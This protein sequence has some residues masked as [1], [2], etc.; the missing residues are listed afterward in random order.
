MAGSDVIHVRLPESAAP[1][2]EEIELLQ[3][4]FDAIVALRFGQSP[5]SERVLGALRADGWQVRS[6][7]GWVAE[8]KRGGESEQVTG[9]TQTEAL[10]HLEQLIKA[11]RV[12]SAP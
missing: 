7:L 11:D 9:A 10:V 4:L 8:A 5:T 1:S 3:G 2:P 6:R 12:M